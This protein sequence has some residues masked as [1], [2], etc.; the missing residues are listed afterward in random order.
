MG[1]Q[2]VGAEV[3]NVDG[4]GCDAL[5]GGSRGDGASPVSTWEVGGVSSEFGGGLCGLTFE[6]RVEEFDFDAE[7]FEEMSVGGA[8]RS[9]RRALSFD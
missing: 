1:S 3:E 8:L 9:E 5:G 2:L 7:A 6:A 4:S